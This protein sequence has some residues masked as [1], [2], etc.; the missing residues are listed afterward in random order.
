MRARLIRT[1]CWLYVLLAINELFDPA[2]HQIIASLIYFA[3]AAFA[4]SIHSETAAVEKD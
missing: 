2:F 4:Y 1:Y 3:M